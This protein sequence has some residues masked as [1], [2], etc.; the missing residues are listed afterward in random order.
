MA[1][2]RHLDGMAGVYAVASQLCLRGITPCFPAV[3]SGADLILDNGVKIQVKC[4]KLRRHPGFDNGVY[5]FDVNKV[6]RKDKRSAGIY[7]FAAFWGVDENRFFIMPAGECT[8]AV[9]VA[10][11][12]SRLY[13]RDPK[14]MSEKVKAN[15][16]AWHLLDINATLQSLEAEVSIEEVNK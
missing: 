4:G 5:C 6:S 3:D 11:R 9:W 16:D 14:S 2:Q 12:G 15:E 13:R 8:G 7:D 1:Y 10:K